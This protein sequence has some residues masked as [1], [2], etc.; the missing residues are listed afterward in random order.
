MRKRLELRVLQVTTHLNTGGI[1]NYIVSLSGA[2][3]ERLVDTVAASSGGNMEK[4]LRDRGI[5]HK[6]L[7]MDT[8]FEFGPKVFKSALTLTG[9]IRQEKIDIIHAHSRVSQAAASLA[10]MMSGA[11][12][13][14]T[15]HGYFQKRSRGVFDTWGKK[16]VAI[17]DA[18]KTHL[19]EDLGVKAGRIELI[20]NG[21]DI[22]QFS[23]RSSDEEVDRIR[24]ELG[25][26]GGP[27]IGTVG[28][29]SPVKGHRFLVEAMRDVVR[30]APDIR[31][32][33]VGSGDEE[34]ELK[35]LAGSLGLKDAIRFF[36]STPDT[37]RFLSAMDVFVFPSVKE[38]LG[39]ALLEAFASGKACV[40]SDTG[41][42]GNVVEDGVTGLLV[43]VGDPP[44]MA[45][46]VLKLIGDAP[47]RRQLGDNARALVVKKFTLDEMA[48][49]MIEFYRGV[50]G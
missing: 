35:N 6:A 44:A 33:I 17:S 31:C 46:A 10:S 28:R 7:E 24:K 13:V 27:V 15:C 18:V 25:A 39:I 14:T 9:I 12:L 41:G 3:K 11:P 22:D 21:V 49:R 1:S 45:K 47:L 48:A 32:L 2:L 5:P 42:I 16:V 20:Y 8:K 4:E 50:I 19:E 23:G 36:P 40:A 30:A 43:P 34:F 29:L 26:R 38:G 37:R